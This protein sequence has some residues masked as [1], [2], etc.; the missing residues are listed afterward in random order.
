MKVMRRVLIWFV[1]GISAGLLGLAVYYFWVLKSLPIGDYRGDP[2]TNIGTDSA[3]KS[4]PEEAVN[5]KK[6]KLA[7]LEKRLRENPKDVT[8]WL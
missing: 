6:S 3:V 4:L 7:E 2:L 1:S 5:Q 8:A